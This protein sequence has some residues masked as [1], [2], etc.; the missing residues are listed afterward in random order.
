MIFKHVAKGALLAATALVAFPAQSWAQA[1]QSA[2]EQDKAQN[3]AGIADIVVT[4][5]RSSESSQRVP[6][7]ITTL[8]TDALRYNVVQSATDLTKEASSLRI[9][10]NVTSPAGLTID[11][12][13]QTQTGTA[14]NDTSSVG[15]YLNDLFLSSAQISGSVLNLHDLERVEVLKGAQGTLYGRNVTAGVVKF[16]TKKPTDKYEASL[17]AGLGNYDRRFVEGVINIPLGDTVAVRVLGSVDDHGGYSY[18]PTVKRE[19]DNQ[20]KW[21]VR[22]ALSW[23]PND[24]FSAMLEGSYGEY[25]ASDFDTRTTYIQPG[26]NAATMNVM[27]ALGINGLSAQ[28][29]APVIFFGAGVPGC[30]GAAGPDFTLPTCKLTPQQFGAAAAAGQA[31]GAALPQVYAAVAAQR[32]APRSQAMSLNSKYRTPAKTRAANGALTLAYEL[33][34]AT[35][36]S[37]TGYD[38]GSSDRFFNVGGGPWIPIYT[39]QNGY[40][41]QWT[42]EVQ[43]VGKWGDRLNYAAGVFFMD[44]KSADNREDSSQD[45]AFPLFLGQ[46]GL[47]ITNGSTQVNSS[48]TKSYA[49]FAQA[50]YEI[51]DNLKFTGGVRYTK[52]DVNVRS[53]GIQKPQAANGFT[54][55]CIGPAPTTSATP[56]AQC[57][58]TASASFGSWNYTAGLDY[59][60]V[61]DVLIYAK[62]SKGFKS[63]GLNVFTGAGAPIQSYAPETTY[64]YEAG[65]KS[66]FLDRKVLFNLTYYHTNYKNIQRAVSFAAGPNLILT[67]TRNAATAQIDGVEGELKV[68]PVT[69]L[70]LGGNLAYIDGRYKNY[71]TTLVFP[72]GPVVQDLSNLQFQGLAKWTYNLYAG[73]DVDVPFGK[74]H[75]QVNWSHRSSANLFENDSYATASGPATP[76]AETRQDPYGVL[77]ASLTL[78]IPKWNSSVTFWGKNVLNERFKISMI[79]LSNNGVGYTWANYSDP[80]TYGVDWT[81]RF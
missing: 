42:E 6:V 29:L 73:Y 78:D 57:F 80:A 22:G 13:G 60:I 27:A 34:D 1:Q 46:S 14:A 69:G 76:L 74:A 12:R 81:I 18:D 20:K 41:S 58:G 31:A 70:E 26:V 3:D 25:R 39:N 21:N 40:S 7:S 55:S 59:T 49:G 28:S 23:K 10:S 72:T 15:V 64:D 30:L 75:A 43:L 63:G 8:S 33:G 5:R 61:P 9:A 54:T 35:I 56:I 24:R 68:A 62:T 37:I 36:K 16:V 66:R 48:H 77:G 17:T 50:T 11:L 32:D 45:G 79:S 67:A 65:V 4:A 2:A 52:E 19:A 51:V 44:R 53:S 71:A 47:G 38:F